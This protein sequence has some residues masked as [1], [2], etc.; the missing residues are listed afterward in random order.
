MKVEDRMTPAEREALRKLE[1]Q[2]RELAWDLD[3]R[4]NPDMT[5]PRDSAHRSTG[6]ALLMFPFGDS[7]HA[8]WISNADRGFMIKAVE[9]WL[10]KAS[11]RS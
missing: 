5:D 4:L 7:G 1:Q 2:A 3:K 6:F 11:G 9:E 8:T 10:R